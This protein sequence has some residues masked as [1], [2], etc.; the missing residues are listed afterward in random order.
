MDSKKVSL[1]LIVSFLFIATISPCAFSMREIP[2]TFDGVDEIA[3][4]NTKNIPLSNV[5]MPKSADKCLPPAL[6]A[7]TFLLNSSELQTTFTRLNLGHYVP[8]LAEVI[9][10]KNKNSTEDTY[11][12]L[13]GFM[14][15]NAILDDETD[16]IINL[17]RNVIEMKK[18][19][20][21]IGRRTEN[22]TLSIE[23]E[24]EF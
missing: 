11:I 8:Q 4:G 9:F 16:G 13:K 21:Y 2:L 19:K 17:Y 20:E 10:D 5:M 15:G 1:F 22:Q 6:D 7:H 18:S 3:T 12:N 24:D 23:A 14:L